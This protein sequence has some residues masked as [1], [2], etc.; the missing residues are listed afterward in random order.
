MSNSTTL[1][2]NN[3][4]KRVAPLQET[5]NQEQELKGH[6]SNE[7]KLCYDLNEGKTSS[8]YMIQ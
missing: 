5:I 8:I 3:P 4:S 7:S 6:L 2:K 1:P